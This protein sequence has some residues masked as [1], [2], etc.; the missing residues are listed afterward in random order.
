MLIAHPRHDLVGIALFVA[1]SFN[2]SD[3]AQ[4]VCQARSRHVTY[5]DK[6]D[7]A[8]QQLLI[9]I[10]S[11]IVGGE[12]KPRSMTSSLLCTGGGSLLAHYD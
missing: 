12:V 4:L 6:V 10:V 9:P 2:L 7:F 5:M 1:N 3:T 8:I 11:R